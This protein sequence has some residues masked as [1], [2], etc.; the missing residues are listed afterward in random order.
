MAVIFVLLLL[1]IGYMLL[2]THLTVLSV[3]YFILWT[4]V[5]ILLSVIT[6]VLL[7]LIF[8]YPYL[9]KSKYN[10]KIKHAI[11]YQFV[12]FL[13][14]LLGFR[15]KVEGKENI[16]YGRKYVVIGNHKSK[17]DVM[18]IYEI[19]KNP[20]AAVAKDN[21]LKVPFLRGLM[22]SIGCIPID[23]GN[24]REA[25]KNL[26]QGYKQVEDGYP[27]MVFPEGGIKTRDTE[28]MVEIRPGAYKLA[29]KPEADIVPVVIKGASKISKNAL[30]RKTK[31]DV[32]I[33][34]PMRY[35]EYKDLTTVELGDHF[36]NLINKE[37]NDE[38]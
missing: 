23:R 26:R 32:K 11:I 4:I 34:E 14:R 3:G 37:F 1:Y 9:L 16:P 38:E 12:W 2:F 24:D 22:Y 28:K 8:I 20:M 13:N 29:T 36:F 7:V 17:C 33:L 30:R 19:F 27:M 21:L 18:I 6:L 31:I 5:S 10:S 15:I 25:L 35:E